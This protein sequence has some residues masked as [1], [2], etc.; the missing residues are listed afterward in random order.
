MFPPPPT[1]L[2]RTVSNSLYK[3]LLEK[4]V[5]SSYE[6]SNYFDLEPPRPKNIYCVLYIFAI[7]SCI[8]PNRT[9]LS[10]SFTYLIAQLPYVRNKASHA[11][12]RIPPPLPAFYIHESGPHPCPHYYLFQ[13]LASSILALKS[14]VSA[15][16]SSTSMPSS[17]S[18]VASCIALA[19]PPR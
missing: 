2:Y 10:I 4:N 18:S 19:Y 9:Y 13:L 11:Q 8:R 15:L 1:R 16:A 5:C 17:H 14:L 3:I 6:H 7:L 12:S